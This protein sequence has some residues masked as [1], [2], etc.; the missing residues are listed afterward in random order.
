MNKALCQMSSSL[1]QVNKVGSS[2]YNPSCCYEVTLA[3]GYISVDFIS[4]YCLDSDQILYQL[5]NRLG[6]VSER[7]ILADVCTS[8]S[9]LSVSSCSSSLYTPNNQDRSHLLPSL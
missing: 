6:T 5:A 4:S 3:L 9:V 2:N 7:G 1:T 8:H